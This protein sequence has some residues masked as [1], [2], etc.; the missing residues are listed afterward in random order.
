MRI[1]YDDLRQ[2][3]S[4][5]VWGTGRIMRKYITKIGAFYP[6]VYDFHAHRG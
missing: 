1:T 6:I 3:N 4:I 5:V 2:H